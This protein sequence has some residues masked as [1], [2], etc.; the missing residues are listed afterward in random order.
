MIAF[1]ISAHPDFTNIG[2][3]EIDCPT[4]MIYGHAWDSAAEIEHFI[5]IDPSNGVVTSLTELNGIEMVSN[6][7]TYSNGEYFA[8][9][10]GGTTIYLV[11]VSV[12]NPSAYS[13]TE[14]DYTNHPELGSVAGIEYNHSGDVIY[15]YAA[16][17]TTGSSGAASPGQSS[18]TNSPDRYLVTVDPSTGLVSKYTELIDVEGIA[19]GASAFDGENYYL[20]AK[21]DGGGYTMLN[22]STDDFSYTTSTVLTSTNTDLM[23]PNGFE[24]NPSTGLIYGYAR[25]SVEEEEVYISYDIATEAIQVVGTIDGVQYVTS[26]ST[27]GGGDFY[28]I[29]AGPDRIPKLV[30]IQY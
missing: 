27:I 5:S 10:R 7:A 15:A 20:N 12:S 2:G 4:N 29:M 1:D 8:I 13:M 14:F 24:I 18:N 28:A 11:H 26:D 30:H 3:I 9:M 19:D 16:D 17:T 6:S 21:M 23:S 22:I 25:D